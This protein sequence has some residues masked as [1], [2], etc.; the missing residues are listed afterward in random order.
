MRIRSYL[1][2]IER[3]ISISASYSDI[4]EEHSSLHEQHQIEQHVER[5]F[6]NTLYNQ[7]MLLPF[8]NAQTLERLSK[9]QKTIAI[10]SSQYRNTQHFRPLIDHLKFCGY[11]VLHLASISNA[12]AHIH[13]MSDEPVLLFPDETNQNELLANR[14]D[15]MQLLYYITTNYNI[16]CILQQEWTGFPLSAFYNGLPYLK[17]VIPPIVC[18][19]HSLS[20]FYEMPST[21]KDYFHENL[22]K[23][24]VWGGYHKDFFYKPSEK[25]IPIGY[26]KLDAYSNLVPSAS[27]S[28]FVVGQHIFL[29]SAVSVLKMLLKLID[30]TDY[31]I[32]YKPHPDEA[33]A[34]IHKLNADIQSMTKNADRF[35]C[36]DPIADYVEDMRTC[37]FIVSYGSNMV[38]DALAMNKPVCLLDSNYTTDPIY[39]QTPGRSLLLQGSDP[40]ATAILKHIDALRANWNAVEEFK[41]GLLSNLFNS[42]EKMYDTI[43]GVCGLAK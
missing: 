2:R 34:S 37:D 6:E 43:S 9:K 27:G 18:M 1:R 32:K 4:L 17:E 33:P 26:N 21:I 12:D 15:C 22:I 13:L 3:F 7:K 42:T 25:V 36:L 5:L 30:G 20:T 14:Y 35:I 29:K 40:S 10:C 41:E 23:Y 16:E 8:I 11:Q 31:I 24:F 19:R 38:A 39:T 28:I